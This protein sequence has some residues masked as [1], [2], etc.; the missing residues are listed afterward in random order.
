MIKASPAY[1]CGGAA[2]VTTTITTILN[3][4]C[5]G[6][7]RASAH[8]S[9]SVEAATVTLSI[10]SWSV[11]LALI[12]LFANA[13]R[14]HVTVPKRA[15]K[16]AT[17]GVSV[18]YLLLAAAATAGTIAWSVLHSLALA[19]TSNEPPPQQPLVMA[20][21]IV[22]AVS[23]FTQGILCGVLLMTASC[24]K[25]YSQWPSLLSYEL[26]AVN[27]SRESI[28]KGACNGDA[29]VTESQ[30]PSLDTITQ[31][32]PSIS[33]TASCHSARY[34]GKTLSQGAGSSSDSTNPNSPRLNRT[35]SAA[36]T[37]AGKSQEHG[38]SQQYQHQFQRSSSQIKRSLDSV[39]L[40]PASALSDRTIIARPEPIRANGSTKANSPD[41]S[42]IHPLFRSCSRTP[43]PT[44]TPSSM[45]LASPE[46]GQ[47]IDQKELQ[48]MRSSR[49]IRPR[50]S[51]RRSPLFEQT[52]H[53]F[54]DRPDD[55]RP[56]SVLSYHG[57]PTGSSTGA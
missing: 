12:L 47:M 43:P 1:L 39:M 29:S 34:S 16:A 8:Q 44:A 20:R 25:K 38:K 15:W 11:V 37:Q 24:N 9:S 56:V 13:S 19:G 7:S 14:A 30:R 55:N 42:N 10:A 53:L 35:Q 46:A 17:F 18:G 23:V 4:V 22:W 28:H 45:V 3:G 57:H 36:H 49:E 21:C 33:R 31:P 51:W 32:Q 27:Q 54:E 48:R 50:A 52:D 40:R 5:Y 26:N 6:S 41:E 2:L